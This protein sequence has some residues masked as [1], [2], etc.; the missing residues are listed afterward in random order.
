[1]NEFLKKNSP[2]PFN[3]NKK[4]HWY[5][6]NCTSK[7][8]WDLYKSNFTVQLLSWE[9]SIQRL[10][11]HYII[12]FIIIS[13]WNC[14]LHA[15]YDILKTQLYFALFCIFDLV[16]VLAQI[17]LNCWCKRVFKFFSPSQIPFETAKL[18]REHSTLQW[19][20]YRFQENNFNINSLESFAL[21]V[22]QG[23]L[24]RKQKKTIFSFRYFA[25]AWIET[26]IHCSCFN[27]FTRLDWSDIISNWN[28]ILFFFI[29]AHISI[30]FLLCMVYVCACVCFSTLTFLIFHSNFTFATFAKSKASTHINSNMKFHIVCSCGSFGTPRC[31]MLIIQKYITLWHEIASML[32]FGL[33]LYWS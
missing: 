24:K 20:M 22:I 31:I 28:W 9:R 16:Y 27:P 14:K 21:P 7:W 15:D 3:R 10:M 18:S 5:Q 23:H 4:I 29:L 32:L 33:Q 1:M 11:R 2:F 13:I 26:P 12:Y 6:I 17:F 8:W 19:T 30:L 25:I